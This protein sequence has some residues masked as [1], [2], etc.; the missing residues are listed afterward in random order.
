MMVYDMR[1]SMFLKGRLCDYFH[2]TEVLSEVLSES[3]LPVAL[4]FPSAESGTDSHC[5]G[6]K[7]KI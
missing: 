6:K 7:K 2:E 4:E 3:S 1:Y 5:Q